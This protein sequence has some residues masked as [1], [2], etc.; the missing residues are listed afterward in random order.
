MVAIREILKGLIVG[1]RSHGCFALAVFVAAMTYN[2]TDLRAEQSP[3]LLEKETGEEVQW[4]FVPR[5]NVSCGYRTLQAY[6]K[7]DRVV[8][9]NCVD[10]KCRWINGNNFTFILWP[11]KTTAPNLEIKPKDARLFYMCRGR[12]GKP[13]CGC[14]QWSPPD[15]AAL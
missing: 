12:P 10:G 14:T 9:L 7:N 1:T 13:I 11:G 3:R 15:E 8:F 2:I 6:K 5:T 4:I